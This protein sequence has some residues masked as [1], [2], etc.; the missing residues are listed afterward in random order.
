MV[1]PP[2]FPPGG[3]AAAHFPFLAPCLQL[4]RPPPPGGA[5]SPLEPARSPHACA[6]RETRSRAGAGPGRVAGRG[7]GRGRPL[8]RLGLREEA[9]RAAKRTIRCF[10]KDQMQSVWCGAAGGLRSSMRLNPCS[11][12]RRRV[13]AVS[14]GGAGSGRPP[15]GGKS[16]SSC[17][18]CAACCSARPLTSAAIIAAI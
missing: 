16:C 12:H 7:W 3:P 1:T 2:R 11:S 6:G 10:L 13:G 14:V 5:A 4:C 9:R 17:P 15:P 8:Q 18:Q